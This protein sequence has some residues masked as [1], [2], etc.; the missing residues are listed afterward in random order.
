MLQ[1]AITLSFTRIRISSDL[2]RAASLQQEYHMSTRPDHIDTPDPVL[3][4]VPNN[5][6]SFLPCPRLTPSRPLRLPR[7]T[8][9]TA[10]AAARRRRRARRVGAGSRRR[11]LE[12]DGPGRG[13]VC[14]A[15]SPRRFVST[16]VQYFI[17]LV[18]RTNCW[19]APPLA[20]F[21]PDVLVTNSSIE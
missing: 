6:A 3:S 15:A 13:G 14:A 17:Y 2:S 21:V 4:V 9:P 16:M 7:P 12:E 1:C 5:N 19:I 20:S 8:P 10:P 11:R 18:F